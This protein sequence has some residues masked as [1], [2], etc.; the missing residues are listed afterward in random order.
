MITLYTGFRD[1]VAHITSNACDYHRRRCLLYA[2]A[3]SQRFE[4]FLYECPELCAGF[5]FEPFVGRVHAAKGR[6]DGN[7]LEVGIL[8][9][10][11]TA[12]EASVDRL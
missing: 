3:V 10:D 11:K 4:N 1:V 5:Y 7:H 2:V 12:L 6:A 8:F 9:E